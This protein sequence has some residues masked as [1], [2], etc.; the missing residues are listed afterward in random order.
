MPQPLSPTTTSSQTRSRPVPQNL[1]SE[2]GRSD[3]SHNPNDGRH[4]SASHRVALSVHVPVQTSGVHAASN[5]PEAPP[6][7][8]CSV[9]Q[10]SR[11]LQGLRQGGVRGTGAPGGGGRRHEPTDA[12]TVER[13][14]RCANHSAPA[15]RPSLG[16]GE[17]GSQTL[18]PAPFG[19]RLCSTAQH[20]VEWG[21]PPGL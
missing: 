5:A 10:R 21:I 7:R 9:R 3:G 15:V 13:C 14:G 20:A 12:Q 8:I 1:R 2:Q 11:L 18:P 16:G 17:G 4:P 19:V 6:R